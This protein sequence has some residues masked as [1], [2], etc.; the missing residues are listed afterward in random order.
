M[1]GS[2]SNLELQRKSCRVV[3]GI[4]GVK[5]GKVVRFLP[6]D[7]NFLSCLETLSSD[8]FRYYAII[9]DKDNG[10]Y[11]HIH[12]VLLASKT[13]RLKQFMNCVADAFKCDVSN[14]SVRETSDIK[15]N[16][17]YLVHKNENDK[18]YKYPYE[19]VMTN[20]NMKDLLTILEAD[21]ENFDELISSESLVDCVK[22][23]NNFME[24]YFKLGYKF[25]DGHIRVIRMLAK[26]YHPDWIEN[27]V[28]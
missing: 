5:D 7:F 26:Q 17:Q 24:L 21:T 16:I 12:L 22:Y 13:L 23:S 4:E 25:I 20:G 14:V 28:I 18:K 15:K 11:R 3:V 9:H 6:K 1:E 19:N 2:T 8:G 10:E 27:G